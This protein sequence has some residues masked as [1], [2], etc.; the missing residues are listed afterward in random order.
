MIIYTHDAS[1]LELV[2]T[3]LRNKCVFSVI[4]VSNAGISNWFQYIIKWCSFMAGCRNRFYIIKSVDNKQHT[5]LKELLSAENF[6]FF[7]PPPPLL[8]FFY[9]H[10]SLI[11]LQ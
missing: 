11:N 8:L 10:Y 1:L 7:S 3:N 6:F 5:Y 9:Y 4:L 2:N